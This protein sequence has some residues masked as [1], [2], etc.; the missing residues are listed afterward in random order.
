MM[1]ITRKT[2]KT[3]RHVLSLTVASLLLSACATTSPLVVNTAK[4]DNAK[5]TF[6][7]AVNAQLRSSFSY[8]TQVHVSTAIRREAL[9]NATPEQLT[10][11]A[12]SEKCENAHDIAYVALLKKV[13]ADKASV[14][15]VRY[16]DERERIK[17]EFL[18]CREARD[19]Q[20]SYQPFDFKNFY[21]Q[22]KDLDDKEQ[23]KTFVS[24]IE[25]HLASQTLPEIDTSH[26]ALDVKKSELLEHYLIRPSSISVVGS[27]QPLQGKFTALPMFDYTAKNLKMMINQPIYID[28]NAGNIYL[29]ADNFG[30]LNSELLDAKLGDQWHNKWLYVPINDGSL[31]PEFAQDL[32]KA[33]IN[34][35]KESFLALPNDGFTQVPANSVSNLPFITQNLP[36]DK[37][38][39]INNTPTIIKNTV[40][41][42]ARAYSDYVFADT[43]FQEMSAKYPILTLQMPDFYERE[44]IDGESV[45]HVVNVETA[46]TTDKSEPE[47]LTWNSELLMRLL[48]AYLQRDINIYYSELQS[49]N[50]PDPKQNGKYA[51]TTHYGIHGGKI[52]WIHQRHY[53]SDNKTPLPVG[54]SHMSESE[55]VLVDVFTQIFQNSK[56]M[57]EFNRLPTAHQAPTAQNSVNLFTYQAKLRERFKTGERPPL[58][59]QY[60]NYLDLGRRAEAG[61]YDE[62]D[63]YY[64]EDEQE[65][66]PA[67][68]EPR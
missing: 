9:A 10:A 13:K 67:M 14:G 17:S 59:E 56:H 25:S 62:Y 30:L 8:E 40:N 3:T 20:L 15:D 53:M 48:F 18:A 5:D 28:L 57:G 24:A 49:G 38:A 66:E 46:D 58:L 42:E 37:L 61:E 26:T 35:K 31:P 50:K 60:F 55:P 47:E 22:T 23:D 34:A 4:T 7:Q 16:D 54:K 65:A 39:L 29:W 51:P 21:E 43:L 52:S 33:Y 12:L 27:Y 45:I 11:V 1:N 44:I 68:T 19:E 41:E 6:G 32:I 2:M 36:S 64:N 63:D